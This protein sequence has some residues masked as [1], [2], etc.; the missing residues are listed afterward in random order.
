MKDSEEFEKVDFNKLQGAASVR[1]QFDK[2]LTKL[3]EKEATID[4]LQTGWETDKTSLRNY[5]AADLVQK[6]GLPNVKLANAIPKDIDL[7]DVKEVTKFFNSIGI[8]V[9]EPAEVEPGSSEAP[10][11]PEIAAEEIDEIKRAQQL[12]RG[13]ESQN[14]SARD[15]IISQMSQAK[16]VYEIQ[17]LGREAAKAGS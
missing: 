1:E 16:D 12:S 4:S 10:N 11:T 6:L 7:S 17:R 13:G 5:Q 3:R 9:A 2:I 8:D 15:A 14:T